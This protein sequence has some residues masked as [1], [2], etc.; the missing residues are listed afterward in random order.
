MLLKLPLA[1]TD[2]LGQRI[3]QAS[4]ITWHKRVGEWVDYGDD[5]CDLHV[6]AILKILARGQVQR[7]RQQVVFGRLN[8][9][10]VADLDWLE[11]MPHDLPEEAAASDR[12]RVVRPR[13]LR[14]GEFVLRLTATDRGMLSQI[15]VGAGQAC[16]DGDLLA[17]FSTDGTD[18][19][20]A[21]ADQVDRA[22]RFR[23]TGNPVPWDQA[24][25]AVEWWDDAEEES[26]G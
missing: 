4:V 8:A 16:G 10:D 13:P 5:V 12:M 22:P 11:E 25:D 14:K 9:D 6:R 23:V 15:A 7:A 2:P 18:Q 24:D 3:A 20:P 26:T 21:S 1:V 19:W 17:C